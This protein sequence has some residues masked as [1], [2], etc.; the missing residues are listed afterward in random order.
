M[1]FGTRVNRLWARAR[2]AREAGGN[3][4]TSTASIGSVERTSGSVRGGRHPLPAYGAIDL[5]TH[6]CRMLVA[7]PDPRRGFRV[8]QSFSR[9]VRLGEGLAADGVL[10]AAAVERAVDALRA[11]ARRLR[12]SQVRRTRCVATEACRRAANATAFVERVRRETGLVL[13][14]VSP[15]EEARLTLAGCL[16]LLDPAFPHVLLFDIGGGSMEV[17]WIAQE[18]PRLPQ[19]LGLR[20]FPVGVVSFAELYGGD[21]LPTDKYA[22]IVSAVDGLL[23]PM[24]AE[25]GIGREV[26]AGRVQMV[27]TSGTV[28][29]LAAAYLRLT[30]YDRSK[31]DGIDLDFDDIAAISSAL[32]TTAWV[33]RAANP[34]IGPERADL[35]VAGCAILDAVCRRW[36]VGRLRVADRG[37]R[38]GLLMAM[39]NQAE[40][41]GTRGSGG[42]G[43]CSA[44]RS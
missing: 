19:F 8:V 41:E 4:M 12:R 17:S 35:V 33:E 14:R 13:E 5:G 43:H 38:E 18:S 6:N 28:T 22:S 34:C 26:A 11:C 16:P 2:E 40:E 10:R 1:Y 31:V 15:D 27:G 3:G 30:R 24:D 44:G 9:P 32:S 39:I 21:R 23:A 25:Y 20:S 37:I 7:K 29:T 42:D 36:P